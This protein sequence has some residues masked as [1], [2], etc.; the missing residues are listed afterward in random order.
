MP[1][2]HHKDDAQWIDS[3]LRTLQDDEREKV[4]IAYSNAFIKVHEAERLPHR[5]D[6]KARFAANNRLRIYIAKKFAVFNK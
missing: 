3:K 2:H 1:Q 6:C 4:C 5:K